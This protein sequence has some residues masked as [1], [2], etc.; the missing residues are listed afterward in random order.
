[1]LFLLPL[2]VA[3]LLYDEFRHDRL[4]AG[5][6]G[7]AVGVGLACRVALAPVALQP[8]DV[9]VYATSAR[10]WFEYG[11]PDV[12]LG[13]TLPFTFSLYWVSYSFYALMLK[14]GF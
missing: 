4:T 8:F 9:N 10:G 6:L 7:L 3:L 5:Q 11:V 2:A 13:P 1:F 14:F 12:S